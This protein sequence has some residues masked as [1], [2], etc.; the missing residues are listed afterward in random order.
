MHATIPTT[1]HT[2]IRSVVHRVSAISASD[3]LHLGGD[4]VG[5]HRAFQRI[6][7]P[8]ERH[9][10][11]ALDAHGVAFHIVGT[12]YPSASCR[13]EG[14]R[15][16]LYGHLLV[17]GEPAGHLLHLH[18]G[19]FGLGGV[20]R[21]GHISHLRDRIARALL[22]VETQFGILALSAFHRRSE[23]D[24][25]LPLLGRLGAHHGQDHQITPVTLA[26]F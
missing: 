26:R 8:E 7:D 2:A 16:T 20:T 6:P 19:H 17:D 1:E 12:V 4:P 5:I 10:D 9:L 24:E 22:K 14:Y 15:R 25:P 21:V 23:I 3:D 13:E 11:L 18:H